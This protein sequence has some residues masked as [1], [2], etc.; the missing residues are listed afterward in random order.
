MTKRVRV[1]D[2]SGLRRITLDRP[3]KINALDRGMMEAVAA[4]VRDAPT[5]DTRLIV[6]TGAG[7]RGFCAGADVAEL[8]A[9]E[10]AL[11]LQ[12]S[13]LE[14]VAAAFANS[15]T[16]IVALLHGRTLGAGGLIACLSTLVLA[17][18]T[19]TIGFPEI[20]FG[21]Y[22]MMVHAALLE[23]VPSA[24][25][26]QLCASGRV[27]SANQA[28]ALGIVTEVLPTETFAAAA[29]ERLHFFSERAEGLML[30][31]QAARLAADLP[32]IPRMA[33]LR[34]LLL[35]NYAQPFVRDLILALARPR[36]PR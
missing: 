19:A 29:E 13:A 12:I 18:E 21:L 36:P 2:T 30:G 24:L 32:L 15:R 9:G 4:A 23:R 34:P 16:P 25:A 35:D 27:L 31:R 7:E 28:Q 11:R 1:E 33:A 22:P 10:A 5:P 20:H 6:L 8:A 3:E 14:A 17:A 26:F